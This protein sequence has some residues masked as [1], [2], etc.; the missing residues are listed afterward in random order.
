MLIA[1]GV[2]GG[3]HRSKRRMNSVLFESSNAVVLRYA[4]L[5]AVDA[6]GRTLPS[7]LEVL[8]REI[9]LIVEDRSTQYPLVVDPL[10]AQ[11]QESTAHDSAVD[12]SLRFGLAEQSR[13]GHRSLSQERF[14]GRRGSVCG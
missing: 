1:L 11:Q 5:M 10:W 9:R 4:D 6:R 8:G 7:R 3:W 14:A 2:A 12:F 13:G